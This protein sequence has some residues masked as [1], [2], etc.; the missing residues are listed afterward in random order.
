VLVRHGATEWSASGRHTGTTDLDLSD[1]G[2]AAAA[3]LAPALAGR[4]FALVLVSP[5]RRAQETAR[6]AGFGDRMELCPDL[7]E[8]D[9]GAYEGRTTADIRTEVPGWTVFSHPVPGGETAEQV[10]ARI[11]RVIARVRAVDGDVA[12]FSHGHALRVFGAR[13]CGLPPTDGRLL[14]L[15]PAA[16]CV[17]GYERETAVIGQWNWHPDVLA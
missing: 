11:D 9:Y 4:A 13:W 15:D 2:R 6:L 10:A 12:V 8:W 14:A 7:H 17:L 1:A 16:V 3:R 5:L